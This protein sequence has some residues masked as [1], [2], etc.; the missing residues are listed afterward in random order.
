MTRT[1]IDKLARS[2]ADMPDE[3][4]TADQLLFLKLK[5]LYALFKLGML[6]ADRGRVEKQKILEQHRADKVAEGIF[7]DSVLISN[8]FSPILAE[9]NKSGCDICKKLVHIFTGLDGRNRA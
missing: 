1:D 4:T 5:Y 2:G 9:A 6:D 8:K 7:H 3:L